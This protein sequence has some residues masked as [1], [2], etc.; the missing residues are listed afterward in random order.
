[1]FGG[2]DSRL[3]ERSPSGARDAT[4]K[5]AV[6]RVEG[7]IME[8]FTDY[9]RKQISQ[10]AEDR[11]V[12]AIVLRINSPGGTITASDDLH[13][14][15]KELRDGNPAKHTPAKPIIVSMGGLA[16]SGGYYIAM[17]AQR[18]FAERT[19][20]TG[21]IGVYASFPNVTGLAKKYGVS[22]DTIKAGDI[23]DSGAMLHEMRPQERQL[24]Q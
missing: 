8:G 23:K 19:T 21:S 24:G 22:M 17:P 14:R 20:T 10:A 3:H 5:V 6:V 7:V 12:K 18:I 16:A 1:G 11:D 2:G 13:H 15:I 4:D 9:A